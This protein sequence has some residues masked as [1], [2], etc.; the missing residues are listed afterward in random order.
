MPQTLASSLK[1]PGLFREKAYI[2]GQWVSSFSNKT[3]Q[4]FN[5]ATEELIGSCPEVSVDDLD[6]TIKAAAAA[7][8]TWRAMSGRQRGRIL[9]RIFDLLGE[10]KEEIGKIIT[11]ENGKAK[12]DAEGEVLFAAGFFKWFSEEA[13][14]I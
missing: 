11:S 12:A 5:P 1:D 9:R 6:H 2:N 4:V 13:A 14:R 3:F 8:P 7:F 10:H